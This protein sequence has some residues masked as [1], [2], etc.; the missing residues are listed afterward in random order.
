[1][2]KSCDNNLAS[3]RWIVKCFSTSRK[4]F[5]TFILSKTF[6]RLAGLTAKCTADK[7]ISWLF[8]KKLTFG[9]SCLCGQ[10]SFYPENYSFKIHNKRLVQKYVVMK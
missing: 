10:T 8:C 6:Q 9:D 7:L 3:G 1:M 5:V 2:L 4:G